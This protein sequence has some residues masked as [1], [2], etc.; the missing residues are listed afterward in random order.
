VGD[1]GEVLLIE[2]AHLQRTGIGVRMTTP[3][4]PTVLV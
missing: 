3:F 2:Q 4:G 1:L